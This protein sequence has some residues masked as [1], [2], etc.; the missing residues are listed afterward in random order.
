MNSGWYWIYLLRT[1]KSVT[2]D[3]FLWY[4]NL[5]DV[6]VFSFRS[7]GSDAESYSYRRVNRSFCS[8]SVWDSVRRKPSS[9][10]RSH[11]K[12]PNPDFHFSSLD[13]RHPSVVLPLPW[14]EYVKCLSGMTPSASRF[15]SQRSILPIVPV[16]INVVSGCSK[17]DVYSW[18]LFKELMFA[19]WSKIPSRFS[20]APA[21]SLPS[22]LISAPP[23]NVWPEAFR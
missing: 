9:G 10:D 23:K 6:A 19:G 18:K 4:P 8:E 1:I 15:P 16:A 7:S 2:E 3:I 13:P 22:I 5:K 11:L 17:K 12:E 14:T 21:L 20:P